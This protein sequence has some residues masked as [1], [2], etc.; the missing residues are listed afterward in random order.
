MN[1]FEKFIKTK[2]YILFYIVYLFEVSIIIESDD[3]F[4]NL[5]SIDIIKNG[6]IMVKKENENKA[7]IFKNVIVYLI[8]YLLVIV[9]YFKYKKRQFFLWLEKQ[10]NFTTNEKI[11]HAIII[12]FRSQV[13]WLFE[14]FLISF[15]VF[16]NKLHDFINLNV[17]SKLI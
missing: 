1:L 3:Y 12:I 13:F 8:I 7:V 5:S 6:S 16:S 10:T 11:I 17:I 15:L 2:I 4:K 14:V 9:L